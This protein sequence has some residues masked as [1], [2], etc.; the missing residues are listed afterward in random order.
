MLHV[1]K[2]IMYS[3]PKAEQE[4]L[5]S[6][7]RAFATRLSAISLKPPQ[8]CSQLAKDVVALNQEGALKFPHVTHTR[9]DRVWTSPQDRK[10]RQEREKFNLKVFLFAIV[11]MVSNLSDFAESFE[12]FSIPFCKLIGGHVLHLHTLFIQMKD[13]KVEQSHSYITL[14]D[15]N[16]EFAFLFQER[17]EYVEELH[18][19]IKHLLSEYSTQYRL[20]PHYTSI[21]K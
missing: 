17:K 21:A 5:P 4:T 7:V 13:Q 19:H 15:E 6:E 16:R 12:S 1:Q 18:Q 3:D 20:F 14:C 9:H 8:N 11:D 2:E 10:A